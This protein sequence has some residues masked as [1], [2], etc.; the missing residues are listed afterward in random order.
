MTPTAL[1]RHFD[2]AGELLY[3]GI[4]LSAITRLAEHQGASPWFRS[5]ARVTIEWL[6]S[7]E[8]AFVAEARAI[9]SERP[10]FNVTHVRQPKPG[11]P[12][13]LARA[14]V[15]LLANGGR[16]VHVNLRKEPREALDFLCAADK[17]TATE[18]ITRALIGVAAEP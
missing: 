16:R 4:S 3:V 10:K 11:R 15:R 6:P 8:D 12:A 2:A 14:K 7:R 18:A 9:R 13:A 5:I 17:V 1:Y